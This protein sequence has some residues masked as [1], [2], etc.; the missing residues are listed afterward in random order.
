MTSNVVFSTINENYPVA[1]V[2][3]D[4]QGFRDNFAIIKQSFQ[5]TKTELEDLQGGVAR[6][7]AANN[8]DGNEIN[9]ANLVATSIKANTTF[10]T[11]STGV[12]DQDLSWGTAGA[13]EIRFTGS[14]N[15]VLTNFVAGEL[16]KMFLVLYS[17]SGGPYTVNIRGIG[18]NFDDGNAAW[19]TGGN[20]GR[21]LS[22]GTS[23]TIVEAYTLD[24]TANLYF[25]YL[26]TFT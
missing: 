23:K 20:G 21:E 16:C 8:F 6:V 9:N 22:I 24:N 7:D 10:T 1:G 18:S 12:G 17:D 15:L 25:R 2:D 5:D 4:S 19:S 13:W 11:L 3:N 26:G 14:S